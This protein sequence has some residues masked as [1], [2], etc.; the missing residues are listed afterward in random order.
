V[1]RTEE[2]ERYLTQS[3]HPFATKTP[4]FLQV[5]T[6]ELIY[7]EVKEFAEKMKNIRRNR[8][9]YWETR[10]AP[11]DIILAGGFTGFVKEAE[12]AVEIAGKHFGLLS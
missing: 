3:N 9:C 5:G 1:L 8:I 11:H 10:N 12:E 2:M 7:D 6:V 4:L